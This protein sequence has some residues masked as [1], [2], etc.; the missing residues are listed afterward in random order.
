MAAFFAAAGHAGCTPATPSQNLLS[1]TKHMKHRTVSSTV[2]AL[3][4]NGATLL[5]QKVRST[6][7]GDNSN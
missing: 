5:K 3:A 7:L 4:R 1:S 2:T 6:P